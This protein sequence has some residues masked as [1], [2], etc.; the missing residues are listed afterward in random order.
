MRKADL[1]D[2]ASTDLWS[3]R[4]LLQILTGDEFELDV[5]A[6]HTHQA[7][8][9]MMKYILNSHGIVFK[10]THI[11]EELCE[12]FE[13]S[14]LELPQWLDINAPMITRW[15]TETRYGDDLVAVKKRVLDILEK[16]EIWHKTIR[17]NRQ[18]QQEQHQA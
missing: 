18:R 14:D 16:S 11:I 17:E 9:K 15:A 2:R 10:K 1:L 8:E 13:E 7:V 5:I 6:Y 4:G 12:Q 3:A